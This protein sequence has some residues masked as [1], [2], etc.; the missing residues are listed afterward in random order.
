MDISSAVNINLTFDPN[1]FGPGPSGSNTL[2]TIPEPDV[3]RSMVS[4]TQPPAVKPK[5]QTRFRDSLISR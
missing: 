4:V 3:Y 1:D 5:P 2:P